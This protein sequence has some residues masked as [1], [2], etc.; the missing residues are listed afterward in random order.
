MNMNHIW[1]YLLWSVIFI[2]GKIINLIVLAAIIITGKIDSYRYNNFLVEEKSIFTTIIINS[3]EK[4]ST[5]KKLQMSQT[6]MISDI[7]VINDDHMMTSS[8]DDRVD[9]CQYFF[10]ISIYCT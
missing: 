9:I 2:I 8:Y 10:H 3:V 6:S 4:N 1:T 7:K 5:F